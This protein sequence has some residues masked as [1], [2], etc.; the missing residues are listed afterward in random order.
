MSKVTPIREAVDRER[1]PMS[2]KAQMVLG[3]IP[4]RDYRR[5]V[6][7]ANGGQVLQFVKPR[8]EER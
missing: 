2:L 8:T 1:R 3:W 5:A 4:E 6:E 7:R